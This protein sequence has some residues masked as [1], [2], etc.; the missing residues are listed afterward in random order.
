MSRT[1]FR[2]DLTVPRVRWSRRTTRGTIG[3]ADRTG[4]TT[5][6]SLEITL[7]KL[8][9]TVRGLRVAHSEDDVLR[10]L[11]QRLGTLYASGAEAH[12]TP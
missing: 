8:G 4:S 9:V 1:G 7:G 6:I 3:G 2:G 5:S 11:A 10:R 12:S